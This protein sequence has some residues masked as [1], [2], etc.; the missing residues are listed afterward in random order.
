MWLF[1]RRILGLIITFLST[2]TVARL[3][4]PSAYGLANMAVVILAFAEIFR[5]F[6][7]TNA[8]LRKGTISQDEMSLIFWFN[9]AVTLSLAFL[10]AAMSPL[11]SRFYHEPIVAPVILVSLAGFILNGLSLQHRALINRELRFSLLAVVDTCALLVGFVVTIVLALLWHDVWCLVV[12][13]VAQSATSS[14]LFVVLSGWIPSRPRPTEEL[15]S[16]LKFGANTLT[17]SVSTFLSNQA[18][19][20]LI[21][22]FLGPGLLGQFTRAQT[23]FT[24]PNSNLVEPIAQATLPLL[25]RLR[26]DPAEYRQAYLGMVR[27]LCAFLMPISI[28][29]AFVGV[30]LAQALLG[31]KWRVAGEVLSALAPSLAAVG[32]GYSISDLFITQ[33]RSSELRTVG[34]LETIIRVGSI[35]VGIHFGVVTVARCYSLS[36]I[37]MV[38]LRLVIVGRRGPVT[39]ADQL[40][41]A[42]PGVPLSI[43]AALGCGL[44]LMAQ[45]NGLANQVAIGQHGFFA[46]VSL[47][48]GALGAVLVGFCFT[49]S[50]AVMFEL[51]ETFGLVHMARTIAHWLRRLNFAGRR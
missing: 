41:A 13:T 47:I 30:P 51:S 45:R 19:P 24:L 26:I 33:D 39:I 25:A 15:P 31:E 38:F 3:V 12:G 4:T 40:M 22:H 32:L 8:V 36:T 2:I 9:A 10:M 48:S 5:D 50:R 44:I 37:P 18:G 35:L 23:L 7:L 1:G 28:A 11:A 27:K 49:P 16:L 46:A 14:L 42:V 29:L 17:F 6:G 21:G 43:G 34:F 20:I